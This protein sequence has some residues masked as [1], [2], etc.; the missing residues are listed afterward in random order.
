[1]IEAMWKT[2][3]REKTKESLDKFLFRRFKVMKLEN[4][5]FDKVPAVLKA[6]EG[7]KAKCINTKATNTNQ[8]DEPV[9]L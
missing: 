8:I 9:D 7:M 4:L 5:P 1:K 3:S 2:I 6:L